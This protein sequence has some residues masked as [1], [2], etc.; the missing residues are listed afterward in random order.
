M[1]TV[2]IERNKLLGIIQE[3]LTTH[4]AEYKEAMIGYRMTVRDRLEKAL[5]KA[6]EGEINRNIFHDLPEPENHENDYK[7]VIRMLEL[8]ADEIIELEEHDFNSYVLDEWMWTARTK[9][10]N[11]FYSASNSA[12]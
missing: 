6:A 3:N 1:Q 12:R 5:A 9:L 4:V 8:S 11:S 2:K 10:S 7:R